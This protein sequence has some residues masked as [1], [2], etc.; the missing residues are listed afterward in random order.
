M[1]FSN[2]LQMWSINEKF[3]KAENNVNL[4]LKKNVKELKLSV[5]LETTTSWK[6]SHLGVEI[7]IYSIKYNISNN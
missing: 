6:I 2:F 3:M 5:C 7:I 1:P 4:I